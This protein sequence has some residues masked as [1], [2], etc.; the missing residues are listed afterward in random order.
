MGTHSPATGVGR[1]ALN[2]SIP[3]DKVNDNYCDCPDGSDEPG[4]AACSH[5]V[6]LPMRQHEACVNGQ[7]YSG[8]PLSARK[9]ACCQTDRVH[10]VAQQWPN[11]LSTQATVFVCKDG[12]TV[13]TAFVDDGVCDCCDGADEGAG[14]PCPN[15]CKAHQHFQVTA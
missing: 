12:N 3:C 9:S 6:S 11:E 10:E 7:L 14:V 4:S 1:R 15:H 13:P 2:A 5:L 8:L